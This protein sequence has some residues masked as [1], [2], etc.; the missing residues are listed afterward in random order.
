MGQLL[1]SSKMG[2]VERAQE[3]QRIEVG[4]RTRSTREMVLCR[5]GLTFRDRLGQRAGG[6]PEKHVVGGA[7]GGA[8]VVPVKVP[9]LGLSPHLCLL[10]CAAV[11]SILTK[12]TRSSAFSIE[13]LN[14]CD[15]V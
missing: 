5:G 1:T 15:F 8:A 6:G 2:S 10:A 4:G 12:R 14:K 13:Y 11:N 7:F 9:C 3:I